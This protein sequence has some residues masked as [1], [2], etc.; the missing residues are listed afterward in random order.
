MLERLKFGYV[1]GKR[2]KLSQPHRL[3]IEIPDVNRTITVA[4]L[5]WSCHSCHVI[6]TDSFL[7]SPLFDYR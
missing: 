3:T 6:V 1:G 2:Y 4:T 5:S 7:S